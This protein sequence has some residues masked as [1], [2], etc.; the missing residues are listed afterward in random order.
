MSELARKQRS[1]II[2]KMIIYIG[3]YVSDKKLFNFKKEDLILGISTSKRHRFK[4][5][6]LI[7]PCS[8]APNQVQI[9]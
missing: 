6:N 7:F 2:K 8:C 5:E 9:A 1:S 3:D 4:K